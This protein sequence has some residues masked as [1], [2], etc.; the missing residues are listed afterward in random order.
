MKNGGTASS[1]S[2][3]AHWVRGFAGACAT[4]KALLLYTLLNALLAAA[5]VSPISSALHQSLDRTPYGER[6]LR[7]PA[8]N[9]AT[10]F[11]HFGRA[12][13]DVFGDLSG[14]EALVTGDVVG[15]AS[16]AGLFSSG[17]ASSLVFFALLV[18]AFSSVLSGGFAGRFGA[19]R[20][21]GSLAAFGA[22][23]G[24]FAFSSL[25]LGFLSLSGTGLLY[26]GLYEAPGRLYDPAALSYEWEATLLMLARLLLFACFAA[27][28]RA[29]VLSARAWI[30]L[31]RN[32][33][34]FL[35]LSSGLGF[36]LGRPL[37]ALSLS[38]WCVAL[39]AI[40]RLAWWA[41]LPTWDG[42]DMGK[43][44]AFLLA[45]QAFV[46]LL[47]ALR[48]SELGAFS[49]WMKRQLGPARATP[50]RDSSPALQVPPSPAGA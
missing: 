3:P 8:P 49:T 4:W 25:V 45:Q 36:V 2:V 11:V 12:R 47:L 21:R 5:L 22:D 15:G 39:L 48:L 43:R 34:P 10:F 37:Q 40:P 27:I 20:D 32:G 13:P 26:L 50:K 17:L 9:L 31:T 16:R 41:F 44:W 1:G 24:R 33:S 14:W 46:F 19:D 30:G 38:A 18:V 35:A 6:L 28:F 23:A 7:A 29:A 42:R